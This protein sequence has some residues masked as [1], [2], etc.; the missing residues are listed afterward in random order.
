[1]IRNKMTS[2][3]GLSKPAKNHPQYD[4]RQDLI[5]KYCHSTLRFN[6]CSS[7]MRPSLAPE[8]TLISLLLCG[9]SGSPEITYS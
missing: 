7:P 4:G 1:M 3:R 9:I 2:S 6:N 8:N 5:H